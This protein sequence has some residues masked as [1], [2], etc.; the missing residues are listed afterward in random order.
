MARKPNA[1]LLDA[2]D[3]FP[4]LELTLT[5]GAS[6][7]LPADLRHP[8][9]VVL[10]NRGAWCPFCVAQL[11][12]FQSGLARLAEEGIGVVSLSADARDQASAMVEEHRL[13]FPVAFGASLDAI[14]GRLGVY[15]DPH[16]THAPPHL[17]SAGFVL[18]PGG[19]VLLAVYSSGAIGR[20]VWQDVLGL[21]KYLK[22]HA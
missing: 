1:S 11:R 7:T 16:P 19:T 15:Y 17:Q 9:G 18:G 4:A 12:A 20:L 5:D 8:Y 3:R 10:V 6:L 22:S 2:G 13:E 21:V 14:A